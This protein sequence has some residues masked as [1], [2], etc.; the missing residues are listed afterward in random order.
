MDAVELARQSAAL[1]HDQV[2]K[3]GFSPWRPYEFALQGARSRGIDVEPTAAGAPVLN[4]G[5][6]T[7]IPDDQLI[8]Y[9]NVGSDFEKAFLIAHEIGHAELGDA[10]SDPVA[11][12]INPARP[13][14]ASPVGLDRVVDYDPRQR[15]EVQMDLF[16]REF[17]IPRALARKL[18]LEGELSATEVATRIG[19]PFN[20]VAQQMLDALLLPAAAT[21]QKAKTTPR[22][23][24]PLQS[25]AVKHRGR[26]FLLEAGPGTGKTQTLT[27]R[28]ESLLAEGVD[29]RR[30]LVLTFSNKA[31]REM[32]ERIAKTRP[33]AAAA[34]WLGT[35]HAF[36]LDL[37]KRFH[38][39]L[40]L[41]AEP[42]MM[43]KTEAVE[44]LENEFP[45]LNLVHYRDYY[46]PTQHIADILAAIS[47]AKDEVV[48]HKQYGELARAM[49]KKATTPE[50]KEEAERAEEVAHVYEAYELLKQEKGR[51]DFGDLVCLPVQLLERDQEIHRHLQELY[52]HVLVDEYQDVNRS[53]V[54]LL[55][56][57]R[58][59]GENLWVVGDAKQSI[60]RFR[61]ASSFNM[62][63][64]GKEDFPDAEAGRLEIN[65]RSVKEI[66]DCFSHFADGMG[67]QKSPGLV[68][69]RG[70]CGQKPEVRT[71]E[72]AEQQA[73]ALAE[74]IE[75]MRGC[76]YA[77]KEQAV[78]CTGNEIL[79]SLGEELERLGV[80]VLFLGSLFERPEVKNLFSL[81]SL[82]IDG[83][84]MG[85]VRVACLPEFS[86]SMPDVT[87][88]L[89]H[90]RQNR[91]AGSEWLQKSGGIKGISPEGTKVLG[92]LAGVL[93][94][95]TQ[96]ASPWIVL[97]SV[98]LDRTRLA[99]QIASSGQISDRTRG[100]AIWQ[101]MNFLGA[102][103]PA[104]GLPI[105]RLLDRVRRL[106]R[107]GDDRDLRQLPGAAQGI[108]A[109]RLM[110]VH[111][112]KGLEFSVVHLPAMNSDTIPR[113]SIP[114]S[115][116]PPEGVVQ[117]GGGSSLDMFRLGHS[118]EQKC[119]FYVGMS[120]ARD[121]LFF[122][123]PTTKSN[124][125]KRSLSP[126]L[127][128]IGCNEPPKNVR[129]KRELP[130][131]PDAV[132]I[133]LAIEGRMRFSAHKMSLYAKCP[134]RFLYTHIIETGGR[135]T[136]SAFM[137]M[138]VAVRTLVQKMCKPNDVSVSAADFEQM[139]DEAFKAEGLADHGY[140]AQYKAF[141]LGMLQYAHS[142]RQGH[143]VAVST[144]LKLTVDGEEIVI[145][146]D[147]LLVKP[148]GTKMVR[149]IETRHHRSS[150]SKDVAAAAF[151]LAAQTAFPGAIVEII[152]LSDKRS[153][154]LSLSPKEL[155]N[156]SEKIKGFLGDIRAGRF[157]AYPS[158]RM[159][160]SCPAFFICGPVPSG[161][162]Q[163]KF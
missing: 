156:R 108:D 162:L 75:E 33:E 3:A 65:Y 51:L 25:A 77:Y 48:D 111:G 79:A 59:S 1:L 16:A 88:V 143:S 69:D 76:G 19:A 46:D 72:R 8:I 115:C 22:N 146:P 157:P 153:E 126:F 74:A 29:P 104:Q 132:D 117:G 30:I 91:S 118:E 58:P 138:H 147:D 116:L 32:A 90:L 39:K 105:A 159:C 34:M 98:L 122:Y 23:L 50:E 112:A 60:Y 73:P 161:P 109:V 44:I 141:A 70:G 151:L 128:E 139:L 2:V 10:P 86:L 64:F 99:A 66:A 9:E 43:D 83:R 124:G 47:R 12:E 113:N 55:S 68:S 28:V 127:Q 144:V 7:F 149:R 6:A 31:A 52:D 100:I 95:F 134:R 101:L 81:L 130:L 96:N 56:A 133:N 129:P 142:V 54:R 26:P 67:G 97:A 102:Q 160:P 37:V 82:L 140:A 152:Y 89:D 13:A 121:R 158:A 106:L 155:Q 21:E 87:V 84:A 38:D 103:P 125:Q 94:G 131:A 135:Q 20:V 35:F 24:N 78:L 136:A 18:H 120:R 42:K 17:L 145:E 93:A 27:A 61:G 110:T 4:G 36:G 63:R 107:L 114:P 137:K 5:R 49:L 119:I 71:V 41:P 150:D 148:D 80:P 92:K 40:G 57:I 154:P 123:A 53:S 85:L 11:R 15:R 62:A 163:K 14:E 45:R